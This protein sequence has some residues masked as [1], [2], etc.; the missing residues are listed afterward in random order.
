MNY[1]EKRKILEFLGKRKETLKAL[2]SEPL[3]MPGSNPLGLA[4]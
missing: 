4:F 1:S 2:G 3:Y